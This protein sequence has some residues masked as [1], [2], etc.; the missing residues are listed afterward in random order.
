MSVEAMET[1]KEA[2]DIQIVASLQFHQ[3]STT[4]DKSLLRIIQS[5][6]IVNDS[7]LN[8][9]Q[10]FTAL[11]VQIH[12]IGAAMWSE[13]AP[14]D[15]KKIGAGERTAARKGRAIA[16]VDPIITPDSM[17]S[18]FS[19]YM[20]E[21]I[22][23]RDD[24]GTKG[25][26]GE[27]GF[28]GLLDPL[29]ESFSKFKS[30]FTAGGD[31]GFAMESLFDK[32][33]ITPGSIRTGKIAK[34]AKGATGLL[35]GLGKSMLGG[36]AALG[37]QMLALTLIMKP[38]QAL[39]DGILAPLEPIVDLFGAVGDILGLLLIPVVMA[40][41]NVLLPFMPLLIEIV[42]GLM[43]LI[44]LMMVPLELLGDVLTA[45]IPIYTQLYGIVG[46]FISFL[47]PMIDFV[48]GFGDF[49]SGGI[50]NF[51]NGVFGELRDW[52]QGIIEDF[53]AMLQNGFDW[54]TDKIEDLFDNFRIGGNN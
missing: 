18:Y 26:G 41:M 24:P 44:R 38:I 52:G 15:G 8:L 19:K 48:T 3:S 39:L 49:I 50:A 43:P 37:P 33:K 40:V 22:A 11:S 20:D 2:A 25:G 9:S 1:F 35:G 51:I 45:T 12:D 5:F 46:D 27:G 29:F 23:K 28:G 7:L 53:G 54:L 6:T 13:F 21:L 42:V 10:Q 36:L 34:G 14:K 4:F 30:D 47:N 31:T 17:V 16:S 32:G